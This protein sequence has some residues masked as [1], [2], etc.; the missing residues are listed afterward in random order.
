MS[1]QQL[2][3]WAKKIHRL[4][5]WV[6]VVLGLV[7]TGGGLVMHQELAGEWVPAA[8]DTSL[9][10]YWHNRLAIPFALFLT[11]MMVTGILMW[12]I[13]KILSKRAKM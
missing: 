9:V 2:F 3:L 6:T 11:A 1:W 10:R 13:P 7:M 8:I 12:G 4:A 5:M